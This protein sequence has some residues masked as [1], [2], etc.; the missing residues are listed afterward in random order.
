MLPIDG[1][2]LTFAS[3]SCSGQIEAVTGGMMAKI[4]LVGYIAELLQERE[5]TLCA[6][7]YAVTLASSFASA[8]AAI[9]K[10]KFDLA[11]LSFSVPEAERNQLALALKDADPRTRI[12][13]TYYAS[14]KNT[15]LAD[16]L[17]Q[18]TASAEDILRAVNHLLSVRDREQAG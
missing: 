11:I 9:Q 3:A 5:R 12:I 6:A 1:I 13:M 10:H 15:E 4:L 18:N 8:S 2:W 7:G 17:M 16:A 14:V